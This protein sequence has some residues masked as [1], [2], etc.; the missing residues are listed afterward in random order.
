MTVVLAALSSLLWGTAD[1]L[2]GNLT[3]RLP[4]LAVALGSQ[5]TGLVSVVAL[6]AVTGADV[7]PAGR[8]WGVA[9]GVV[10]AGALAV[11]YLALAGGVMSLVAPVSATGAVVPVVVAVAGG[12]AAGPLALGGMALAVAGAAGCGLVPGR[13]VL[14]RRAL[15]LAILAA[16]GIGT[17]LAL[18][19]QAAQASSGLGAVLT[20]RAAGATVLGSACLVLAG[21]PLRGLRRA[22]GALRLAMLV[23]LL[24]TGANALFSV[25]SEDADGAA[26]VAVLGSLYPLMTLVLARLALGE[27]LVPV[28]ALAAGAAL[29]GAAIATAA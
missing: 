10:G 11:F 4:V 28:Q 12:D 8:G 5:L 17:F 6:V 29:T 25:A 13:I 16:L 15:G 20:A 27:R 1:F 24:D 21:R 3:R 26:L 19:Q 23:G 7:S 18:L 9:A 22:G 14:T 2:G